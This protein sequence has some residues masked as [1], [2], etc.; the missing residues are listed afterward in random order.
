MINDNLAMWGIGLFPSHH[1]GYVLTAY[2]R[3]MKGLQT[4]PD[5]LFPENKSLCLW[6]KLLLKQEFLH[7]YSGNPFPNL[8]GIQ[9]GLAGGAVYP[10]NLGSDYHTHH[11]TKFF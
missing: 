6:R 2:G 8:A 7:D 9:V 10:S 11:H 5:Q 1:V 4:A 3:I